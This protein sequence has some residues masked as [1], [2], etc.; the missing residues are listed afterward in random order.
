MSVIPLSQSRQALLACPHSYVE[1]IIRGNK[2]PSSEAS[3]RG[4]EIHHFLSEYVRHLIKDRLKKDFAWFDYHLEGIKPDARAVL[5]ELRKD[6]EINPEAVLGTEYKITLDEDFRPCPVAAAAYEMTLDRITI[7]SDTEAEIDDYKSNFQAFEA[8]TFQGKL[9]SLGLFMTMPSLEKV[10]FRLQFVRWN[11]DKVVKFTRDDIPALQEE[12]RTWRRV[13]VNLHQMNA[14]EGSNPKIVNYPVLSGSHCVYCPLLAAGCPIEKNPYK[15]PTGQLF[16]VLYFKA[17]LKRAEEAVRANADRLGPITV[18]D[19]IGTE[20]TGAWTLKEKRSY[21]V[22][23]LPV[24]L[25][26]DK[27]KKDDLLHKLTVSGLSSPLKAKKRAA[28][29]DELANFVEIKTESQ[30]KVRKVK[31]DEE[32]GGADE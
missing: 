32:E 14:F 29:V 17:A 16:N 5:E 11:R 4:T 21:D 25:A 24:I 13:Q 3:V 7:L 8:D 1:Q 27:K 30:F 28:L 15:D 12:A 23:C 22:N 6:F 20:Y 10:T 19:G 26:W 9:Y 2:G 18:R 31:E